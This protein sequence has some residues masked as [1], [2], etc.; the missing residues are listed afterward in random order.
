MRSLSQRLPL[1]TEF[2]STLAMGIQARF[3]FF[4][5]RSI[6]RKVFI[7][8]HAAGETASWWDKELNLLPAPPAH[9]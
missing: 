6:A 2:Q 8:I 9:G 3:A 1:L 5:P 4:L 7:S